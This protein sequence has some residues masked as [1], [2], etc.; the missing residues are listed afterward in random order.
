MSVHVVKVPDIGEGIAEVELVA[1]H[2]R[3]GDSVEA[4]QLIAD[5]MTD[6]ATVEIPSPVS[7]RVLALGGKAGDKLAVGG[8]LLRIEGDASGGA[9]ARPSGAPATVAAAKLAPSVVAP[10]SS[11]AVAKP[12]ASPSVR[13]QA[14]ELGIELGEVRG[15]GSDGRIV[16][17]DLEQHANRGA[18]MPAG[19]TRFAK[20]GGEEAVPVI[21]LRR[22]IA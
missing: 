19:A 4:D 16:R 3:S 12:L 10:A 20:R 1:W 6:K 9:D 15:S 14:R 8:E 13:R 21:G 7:G 22:Q 18:A 11:S 17:E 5:V 2:V